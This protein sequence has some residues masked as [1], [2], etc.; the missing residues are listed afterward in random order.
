V[1][2]MDHSRLIG[3]E[4]ISKQVQVLLA[5]SRDP[6]AA[7]LFNAMGK[8]NPNQALHADLRALVSRSWSARII[9]WY[10]DGDLRDPERAKAK[11]TRLPE[12]AVAEPG[13]VDELFERSAIRILVPVRV[14]IP[15]DGPSFRDMQVVRITGDSDFKKANRE[16]QWSWAMGAGD[17]AGALDHAQRLVELDHLNAKY[18]LWLGATLS[19]LGRVEE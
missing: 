19:K 13:S 2:F 5:G 3:K 10:R 8:A 6:G 18:H 17:A 16:K 14:H 11:M 15:G 4:R 7:H 9:E 1:W 12:F